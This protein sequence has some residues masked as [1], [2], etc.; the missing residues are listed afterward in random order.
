MDETRPDP[1]EA[2]QNHLKS[3]EYLAFISDFPEIGEHLSRQDEALQFA[4]RKNELFLAAASRR[5][6]ATQRAASSIKLYVFISFLLGA[7][8]VAGYWWTSS[9]R[10]YYECVASKAPAAHSNRGANLAVQACRKLYK[11]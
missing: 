4:L 2:Y 11:H 8:L 10:S 7:A 9:P 1:L 3:P 6:S 5:V